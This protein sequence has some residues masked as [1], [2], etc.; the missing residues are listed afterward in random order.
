MK[1]SDRIIVNI[2]YFSVKYLPFLFPKS[3]REH[4]NKYVTNVFEELCIES[5]LSDTSDTGTLESFIIGAK[6]ISKIIIINYL[7]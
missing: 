6:N 7:I 5:Y 4:L 1:E 2:L 3:L